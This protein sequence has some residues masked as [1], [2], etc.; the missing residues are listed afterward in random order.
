MEIPSSA[1]PLHIETQTSTPE[2]MISVSQYA[3]HS[4]ED[5]TSAKNR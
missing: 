4:H 3:L 1:S 2:S 5:L